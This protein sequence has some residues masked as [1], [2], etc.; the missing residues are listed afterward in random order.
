MCRNV[1]L[2]AS[3]ARVPG[4]RLGAQLPLESCPGCCCSAWQAWPGP[5]Q[6]PGISCCGIPRRFTITGIFLTPEVKMSDERQ[7]HG[8]LWVC[9]WVQQNTRGGFAF[10][11]AYLWWLCFSLPLDSQ[12]ILRW[13]HTLPPPFTDQYSE[14]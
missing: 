10:L 9:S 4:R 12:V 5:C 1:A 14:E 13:N 8:L 3:P 2:P 7:I 6:D 11:M